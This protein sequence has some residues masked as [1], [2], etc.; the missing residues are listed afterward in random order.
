MT[1]QPILSEFPCLRE[2]IIFS[3]LSVYVLANN[4][5]NWNLPNKHGL[6]ESVQKIHAKATY[7]D[8]AL[9]FLSPQLK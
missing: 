7:F 4:R 2:K 3:F 6:G 9:P 5:S 1:L 8:L